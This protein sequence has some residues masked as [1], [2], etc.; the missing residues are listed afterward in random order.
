VKFSELDRLLEKNGFSLVKEM[1]STGYYGK[2]NWDRLIRI[3]DHG[4]NEVPTATCNGILKAAGIK[5]T[6]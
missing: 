3:D 6:R 4:S 2:K 5:K 1:G